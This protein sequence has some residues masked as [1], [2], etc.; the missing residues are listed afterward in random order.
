MNAA[1]PSVLIVEDERPL[2]RALSLKLQHEG[3]T[4]EIVTDGEAA[5]AAL[6][7]DTQ[8]DV[9]ILDL[10]MPRKNGFDVLMFMRENDIT[11]PTIVLSNLSQEEDTAKAKELGARDVFIKANTSLSDIVSYIATL[12]SV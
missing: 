5:C 10:V 8:Y 6:A 9:V 3:Y 4:T 2:A 1:Q 7:G 11:T 12:R